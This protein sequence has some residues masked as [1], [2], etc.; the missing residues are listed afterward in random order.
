MLRLFKQIEQEKYELRIISR[1]LQREQIVEKLKNKHNISGTIREQKQQ[2]RAKR[3]ELNDDT[4]QEEDDDVQPVTPE[5][6]VVPDAPVVDPEN[7]NVI[8]D[9]QPPEESNP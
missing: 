8:P 3:R 2:V 6:V 4:I 5:V 9:P 1:D 7:A